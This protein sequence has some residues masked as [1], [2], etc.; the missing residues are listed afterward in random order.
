MKRKSVVVAD[1]LVAVLRPTLN[2]VLLSVALIAGTLALTSCGGPAD[3]A[4]SGATSNP[5]M[6][7]MHQAQPA[8]AAGSS[9]PD[10]NGTPAAGTH[11]DA[12][13]A[14]ATGMIVHHAQAV[15]MADMALAQASSSEV[16][17]L[18]AAIKAA[19]GPEIERMSGCLTSWGMPVPE[20]MGHTMEMTGGSTDSAMGG[21]MSEQDM[22][23]LSKTAGPAFDRAWLTGM[24]AH[25]QGAVTMAQAE[26][27]AGS[28][29]DAMQLARDIMSSQ[30]AEI[31]RMQGMLKSLPQ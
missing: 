3:T 20:T 31:T 14:F 17:E 22:T 19:Q 24:T 13:V 10:G 4:G 1:S 26:L 5:S 28:N 18:A 9:S 21:M 8:A 11:G 23:T 27:K 16:K 6:G 29:A 7:E 30:T 25:H 15:R 12:D 2:L